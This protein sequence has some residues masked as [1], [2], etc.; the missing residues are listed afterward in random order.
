MS[1]ELLDACEKLGMPHPKTWLFDPA[2]GLA[3]IR[4][5]L[6]Y[7]ELLRDVRLGRVRTVALFDPEHAVYDAADVDMY[8]AY[9]KTPPGSDGAAIVQ[10]REGFRFGDEAASDR[11]VVS[12]DDPALVAD[13]QVTN[14]LYPAG[15]VVA[16]ANVGGLPSQGEIHAGIGTSAAGLMDFHRDGVATGDERGH[17]NSGVLPPSFI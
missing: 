4:K 12:E 10:Y 5:K 7:A 3:L 2:T 16:T 11:R 6:T 13:P 15:G 17:W 1:Q 14:E 9:G 8:G